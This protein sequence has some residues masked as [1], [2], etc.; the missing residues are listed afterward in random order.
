[1][2]LVSWNVNGLRAVHG[3]GDLRWAFEGDTAVDVLCLQETKIQADAITPE[4][5]APPGYRSFF[6]VGKRKGYSGT[7]IFVRDSIDVQPRT[8]LIGGEGDPHKYDNEG[9]ICAVDIRVGDVHFVV[10]NTY[11]PNGGS[12]PDYKHA[13][14]DAL[15]AALAPLRAQHPVL[16]C[17]D[18]NIAH[19]DID[20]AKPH[21]WGGLS[22]CLPVERKWL[23]QLF[24][25]GYLDSLRAIKGPQGRMYSFWETRVDARRDNHGWRIDYWLVP[26]SWDEM[27]QDAWLS[28][29][30]FGSDHCPAGIELSLPAHP[31]RSTMTTIS[32]GEQAIDVSD[33]DGD[34]DD[35]DEDNES[36][37]RR[38]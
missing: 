37:H 6:S 21:E 3:R 31:V 11:C 17:G 35:D 20:I 24:D 32:A 9:R 38:R 33:D 26:T 29:Q 7:A 36:T 13:W 12:R 25:S 27:L 15:T 28:P 19:Q 22:G 1:M 5:R 4:M 2:R 8:L 18:L 16:L 30:I 10:V 23:S 14:H 34:V